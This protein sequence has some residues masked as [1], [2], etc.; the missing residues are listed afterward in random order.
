MA[1]HAKASLEP[2]GSSPASFSPPGSPQQRD[3]MVSSQEITSQFASARSKEDWENLDGSELIFT[4]DKDEEE[5]AANLPENAVL[6]VDTGQCEDQPGSSFHRP[7]PL[8]SPP[9]LGFLT[10]IP[11][12]HLPGFSPQSSIAPLTLQASPGP[13]PLINLVKSL[14]TE[15]QAKESCP[16]KPQ[17]L[18]NL[19]KSIST[20]IPHLEP[21]V[22]PSKSDSKLNVH[23]WRQITQ[24]KSRDGDSRTAPSSPNISPSESK[25]SFFRVQEAKFEDTKRRFSE[26][27]QEPL[28]RLSKIIGDENSVSA[29]YK[30][31]HAGAYVH[32]PPSSHSGDCTSAD[33]QAAR[34]SPGKAQRNRAGEHANKA[35]RR[36]QAKDG[37]P[38]EHKCGP[39]FNCRYEI[40]SCG[41]VIQVVEVEQSET[42][43][44]EAQLRQPPDQLPRAQPGSPVPCKTLA[45]I[46]ILAYNYFILPLP[47]YLSGLCLGL[48]CGFMLGFLVILLFVPKPCLA[49]RWEESPQDKLR[50]ELLTRKPREPDVLKSWMNEMY[51][52][53]PEIYHP[54]LTHSVFV[55]LEGAAM[56]LSYPKNNVPRR[57]TFEEETLDVAFVSHR[58]YDMSNAQV[59]LFP[60]GLARK[61]LWNKKYPICILFPDQEDQNFRSSNEHDMDLPRDES[62]T[63]TSGQDI[64]LKPPGDLRERTLYLF[65]RTGRDK[66][67]WFQ[68]L[69][70]ASQ[71]D[72]HEVQSTSWSEGKFGF[73]PN[74][75]SSPS[76][77]GTCS[78]DSSR[79]STEDIPSL[80][81]PKDLAGTVRQK[82]LLDYSAYMSRLVQPETGTSPLQSPCHSGVGS[83]TCQKLLG[84][85]NGRSELSLAWMNALVGRIFW[86]FLREKYWMDQVSNKIQ[87]KLSKIKLPYFMNELTLTELDMGTSIPLVLSVSSPIID[88]QGLWVDV[89]VLY[90]GSLQMTLE[91]K[92]NLCKLGKEALAEESGQT[93]AGEEGA[94]PRGI[95]LADSDAESSSAGSS[96]EEDI[97]ATE[98]SGALGERIVPPPAEGHGGG[99][100][101]TSRKI[102]RLVDK[103]AKSKYFQKATENEFIKKKIEEVSNTP[104]LL[105]VEVQ[106][107]AGTLAVNIPPP[108][109]DRIWYSFR[110]P[111]QLELKVHPKLGEREVTFIHV[112]EWIE[113]KLQHEFQKILV[114]PNM[115]DLLIPIMHS[116][117]EPQPPMEGPFK[118]LPADS[119]KRL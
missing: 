66:E 22:T 64:P 96:D 13:K 9:E 75:L 16:L 53:D 102:L 14:S 4:L 108:P 69:T 49:P 119:E 62:L 11:F 83:P 82:I 68:H 61:R 46:A 103:I 72:G 20:E 43:P 65:G 44:E 88:N 2:E 89:E 52:Y 51:F 116:G 63:R 33:A 8:A 106:E 10:D 41:D 34:P 115:D 12:Y 78:S 87:K 55:T 92:M 100:N 74:Q 112:T 42:G 77:K 40:C 84:D 73:G 109:T 21:E 60:P 56:K 97:L 31:P 25:G 105:T 95:L 85:M 79:G 54:S 111:P 71:G 1:A 27:I 38:L 80:F 99:G 7:F 93:A 94:K 98:P 117:L 29:K 107:L 39:A 23:L 118:D 15:I 5:G 104:L 17:P 76:G 81:R 70:T 113:R 24:P 28:S 32:D 19:V 58:S 6:Y 59:F 114:M 86:D 30:L 101:S 36:T 26:A 48:A 47:P 110:I 57:A 35:T 50:S 90:N 18:L 91:T 45:C 67:E 3:P 37:F